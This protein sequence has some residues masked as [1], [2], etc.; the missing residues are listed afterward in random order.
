MV[1]F[2]EM[3][4]CYICVC[5]CVC[6][7]LQVVSTCVG[8][9]PEVLPSDLIRLADPNVSCECHVTCLLRLHKYGLSLLALV[10]E[11]DKAIHA[12]R[13]G[14]RVP[15]HQMHE[16]VQEMYTWQN[17]AERTEKVRVQQQPL[18]DLK[19]TP[20]PPLLHTQVYDSIACVSP[21]SYTE[22]VHRYMLYS[23]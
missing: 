1:V 3:K 11:V 9:V 16:R 18:L 4:T 20:S 2:L 7:S 22:R 12:H 17:V 19:H 15:A 21:R 13:R 23:E 8:G 5:V 6:A 14:D 10:T